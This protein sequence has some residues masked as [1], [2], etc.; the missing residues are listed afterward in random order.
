MSRSPF[1]VIFMG[2]PDFAVP[3]LTALIDGPDSIDAVIT[4]PDR[5]QGR[6]RKLVA[7]PIKAL[8]TR[9]HLNV[10]QPDKIKSEEFTDTLQDLRPDVIVVAAYGRILP[11]QILCLPR[12]GCINVHG[13]LLP[14]HRGAAPIQWSIIKGDPKV[15][16]TIIQMDE[17]M[18]TGD[19]LHQASITPA[20]DET[21]GSL[22]PKLAE[23]GSLALMETL[24]QLRSQKLTATR[25]DSSQATAAPMFTKHDGLI[26]WNHPAQQLDCL[27]RGLDPWPT[28]FC[29]IN[30]QKL[31]LYSPE[32]IHQDSSEKPGTLLRA[33]RAGLLVSTA[34]SCLLIKE[35]K[36]AGKKRMDV[37]AFLNGYPLQVGS[38]LSGR[39]S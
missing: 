1:R 17:G 11:P 19:I 16:V 13:S 38:H 29:N 31:Q 24:E 22:Y 34:H 21:A 8:A 7:P 12:H 23:L 2:T 10:L 5:P 18:D 20:T 33:D 25:Q 37:A 26:D 6:S 15:G 35:V 4:Q 9:H 3:C 36:P 27:I 30:G 14:R 39:E 28:A 32:V